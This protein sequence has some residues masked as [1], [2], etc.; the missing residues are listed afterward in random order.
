MNL[1][2]KTAARSVADE[3]V[4]L[5]NQLS[6]HVESQLKNIYHL[7]NT[8]GEEQNILNEFGANGVAA[9]TAYI[10]FHTAVTTTNPSHTAPPPNTDI[11]QPQPDGTVLFVPP[12]EPEPEVLPDPEV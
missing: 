12:P 9:L 1:I 6:T 10:A 4:E 11:F 7:A 5:T 3:I 8:P 2:N